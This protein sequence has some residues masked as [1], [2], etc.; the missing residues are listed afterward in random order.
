MNTINKISK[1][2]LIY[3]TIVIAGSIFIV[4]KLLGKRKV[5]KNF[6]D[7]SKKKATLK[8][9]LF[10]DNLMKGVQIRQSSN[11]DNSESL[12]SVNNKFVKMKKFIEKVSKQYEKTITQEEKE[13][14]SEKGQIH[15][16]SIKSS[17]KKDQIFYYLLNNISTMMIQTNEQKS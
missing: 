11:L 2:A 17:T 16:S 3:S 15:I 12:D 9:K 6:Y 10:F 7:K 5:N 8:T 1:E 13:I 14:K 4:K